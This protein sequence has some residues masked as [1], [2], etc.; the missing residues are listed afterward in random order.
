MLQYV[1]SSGGGPGAHRNRD[2]A[3]QDEARCLSDGLRAYWSIRT[4]SDVL[5]MLIER[6][7]LYLMQAD[8]K[9][10]TWYDHGE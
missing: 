1:A 9:L 7:S 6:L 10:D 5:N 8:P 4:W 3:P 2:P